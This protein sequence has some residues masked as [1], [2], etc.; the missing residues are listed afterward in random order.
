MPH[1]APTMAVL[2]A[3]LCFACQ[4]N[5]DN[6][7]FDSD[8]NQVNSSVGQNG[9]ASGNANGTGGDANATG[10]VQTGATAG[11]NGNVSQSANQATAQGPRFI[12]RVPTNQ[13]LSWPGNAV[14]AQF[15]GTKLSATFTVSSGTSYVGI[16]V[17]GGSPQK[18]LVQNN[19]A[20]GVSGLTQGTHTVRF[21]KLNEAELGTFKLA[22]LTS[23]GTVLATPAAARRIE[24]VGDS[25][26]LGYGVEG[27]RPCDNNSAME[28]VLKAWSGV[29][30]TALGADVSVIAW[31][32]HG[33]M[34]N[35]VG[36][37]DTATMAD[38]YLRT[39]ATDTTATYGFPQASTPQ[40]VVINLGTNDFT[41]LASGSD[42][43]REM[44]DQNAF[45]S[46]YVTFVKAIRGRYPQ[47]TIV[48]ASS[49]MLTDTYPTAAEAQHTSQL[50]AITA[51]QTQLS[52]PNVRVLDI[53]TMDT[54]VS[55]CDYHPS[56]AEQGTMSGLLVTELKSALGWQ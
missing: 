31:S 55:A 17:D 50:K 30:G 20:I 47:A 10:T 38:I 29:T 24:F 27:T 33:L 51:V 2:A 56:A 19:N 21:T 7:A 9:N 28:N 5:K 53:P 8:P 11:Q 43:Q 13:T 54:T 48:L 22:S 16:S 26:T 37:S 42:A 6:A 3:A 4:L 35:A 36:V 49:P 34:R 40:A 46:A 45:T 41:Y 18:T 12:G 14:E 39:A 25:I 44:L 52:D 15:T 23:D 32:G 1:K